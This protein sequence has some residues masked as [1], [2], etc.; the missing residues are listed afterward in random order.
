MA[1]SETGLKPQLPV[2]DFSDTK[3]AFAHKDNSELKRTAWLFQ[4]MNKPWLVGIGSQVGL[5]LNKRKI[6]VFDPIV[7][8]TIFRQFCGGTS[9]EE[10]VEA[11]HHLNENKVLAI[12][13][14]GAEGKTKEVEFDETMAEN[15]KAIR[16]AKINKGVP[17]I[18]T[19]LTALASFDLLE[20]YQ[21]GVAL[22]DSEKAAFEKVK[23]RVDV[24]CSEAQNAGIALFV[25]AEETWIQ[26]PI[27]EITKIMMEKYNREKV[28]VYNTYQMYRKDKL[29]DLKN[30]HLEAVSKGYK[31][32]AKVVR[33]AYI[34]KERKRAEEMGYP[35]PIQNTKADTDN[36][37]N[38]AITYCVDHYQEIASC[39]ATHN[40]RSNLLQAELIAKKGLPKNHAHLNFCQLYGM[41][42]NITFNLANGGYN[43]AKI[44]PYGP[45]F[46]VVPYLIRRAK[47]NTAVTGD[48]SRELKLIMDEMRRRGL[49]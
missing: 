38:T 20:K 41:S 40:L 1:N 48:M 19:K 31:L 36:D 29:Q 26:K 33:G 15:I 17:V 47:E 14:Y 16:F 39:N 21:T 34:D 42:D 13:D 11:I 7:K 5:W 6:S 4:F 12:L 25:D 2:V 27:D 10:S 49:K 32:G 45:V 44:V 8:A 24:L 23:Q 3:T 35:S 28:I 22:S 43:V 9:L 18:A 37:F 46:E 30:D